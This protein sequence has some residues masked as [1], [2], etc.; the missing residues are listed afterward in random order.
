MPTPNHHPEQSRGLTWLLFRL[1]GAIILWLEYHFPKHGDAWGSA[2][3]FGKPSFEVLYSLGFWAVLV[4]VLLM[5]VFGGD[6]HH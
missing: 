2:R 4:A 5:L 3:R 1:P 6:G